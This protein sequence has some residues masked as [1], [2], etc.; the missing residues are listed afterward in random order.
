MNNRNKNAVRKQQT[1][2][3][4]VDTLS[5]DVPIRAVHDQITRAACL[6]DAQYQKRDA[7]AKCVT[8]CYFEKTDQTGVNA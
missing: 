4:H 8:V 1:Q 2:T 6:R 5:A 7:E 3:Q